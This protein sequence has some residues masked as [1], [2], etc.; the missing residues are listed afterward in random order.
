[1]NTE[2][3]G[4]HQ[5]GRLAFPEPLWETWEE[6]AFCGAP[7][8]PGNA[9]RGGWPGPIHPRPLSTL[10]HADGA[11][12][13]VMLAFLGTSSWQTQAVRVLGT[14]RTLFFHPPTS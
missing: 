10:F 5:L 3:S 13:L 11:A 9:S 14:A 8:T 1:M 4:A 12:P 7:G 6:E 2:H